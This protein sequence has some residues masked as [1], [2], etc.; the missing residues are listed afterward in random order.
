MIVVD[1]NIDSIFIK[2]LSEFEIIAIRNFAPG[3]SDKKI[4]ELARKYNAIFITEDKDRVCH[5]L[6]LA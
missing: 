1:E 4:I 2:H 5:A 3:I 6:S